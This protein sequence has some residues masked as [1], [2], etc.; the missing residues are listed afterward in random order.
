MAVVQPDLPAPALSMEHCQE[1]GER[2]TA[3]PVGRSCNEGVLC[4]PLGSPP[5]EIVVLSSLQTYQGLF[6][7]PSLSELGSSDSTTAAHPP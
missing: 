7:A 2:S 5:M 3:W 1:V 6:R 4:S